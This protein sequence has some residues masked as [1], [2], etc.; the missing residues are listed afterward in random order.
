[1]CLDLQL[2]I[3]RLNM[4]ECWGQLKKER[5]NRNETQSGNQGLAAILSFIFYFPIQAQLNANMDFFN[6][7]YF[8][9]LVFTIGYVFYEFLIP[10]HQQIRCAWV[11][12]LALIHIHSLPVWEFTHPNRHSQRQLRT[13]RGHEKFW[14]LSRPDFRG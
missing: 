13:V 14:A 8:F 1:M 10:V 6:H 5:K 12:T 9:F 11:H 3:I 4:D 2:Y 7:Y